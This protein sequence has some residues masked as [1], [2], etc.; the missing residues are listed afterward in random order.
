M[1]ITTSYLKDINFTFR[2][3]AVGDTLDLDEVGTSD[4]DQVGV[5]L[6]LGLVEAL[7]DRQPVDRPLALE[8]Q[9]LQALDKTLPINQN[10]DAIGS[11]LQ[12]RFTIV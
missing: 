6:D 7:D 11:H 5:V 3:S 10:G 2:S 1:S 8:R 12:D 4:F 9:L